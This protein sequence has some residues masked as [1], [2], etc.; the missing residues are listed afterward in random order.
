MLQGNP[1]QAENLASE[2]RSCMIG[3]LATL[4]LSIFDAYDTLTLD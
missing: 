3:K 2:I 4:F 1:L